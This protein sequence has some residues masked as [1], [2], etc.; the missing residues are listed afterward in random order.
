MSTVDR[1]KAFAKGVSFPAI[2]VV[3]IKDRYNRLVTELKTE[4]YNL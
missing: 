2:V 4:Q 1:M 3:D